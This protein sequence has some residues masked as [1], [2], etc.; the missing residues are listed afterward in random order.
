MTTIKVKSGSSYVVP[1]LNQANL[2]S[3]PIAKIPA[4]QHYYYKLSGSAG[5]KDT[6]S[7]G[8]YGDDG[9]AMV[10]PTGGG[11]AHENRPLS[12]AVSMW[13]RTA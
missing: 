11:Q 8:N 3:I 13:R 6:A 2:P 12:Y 4:H 9:S 10:T 5:V 7:G 1:V